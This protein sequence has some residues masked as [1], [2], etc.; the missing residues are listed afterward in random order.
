[1]FNSD[2]K[3]KNRNNILDE[4]YKI[5]IKN[6]IRFVCIGNP[7]Y[8]NNE[9]GDIDILIKQNDIQKGI[10]LIRNLFENFQ[11]IFFLERVTMST[12]YSNNI[13]FLIEINDDNSP[14]LQIDL[15]DSLHWK[16]F[17]Y[18]HYDELTN[19]IIK[20]KNIYILKGFTNNYL[21]VLKDILYKN[22]IN[23][24]RNLD[25]LLFSDIENFIYDIGF[26]KNCSKK[27]LKNY[28]KNLISKLIFINMWLKKSSFFYLKG[29]FFFYKNSLIAYINTLFKNKMIVFYGPDGAGKSFLISKIHQKEILFRYFDEIII[30]HSKP[31]II[32]PLSKFKNLFLKSLKNKDIKRDTIPM[33]PITS[34]LHCL[35][36]GFD[37]FLEKISINFS[38]ISPK[39]KL[40]IYDRHVYEMA[41]QQTFKKLPII[42]ISFLKLI[43]I[44]PLIAFFITGNPKNIFK[45]KQELSED[46]IKYQINK[47]KHLDKNYSLGTIYIDNSSEDFNTTVEKIMEIIKNKI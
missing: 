7:Y 28:Q 11:N 34:I 23:S 45:R 31:K 20:N 43:S 40:F 16:G 30:N 1:M 17:I 41:Y 5:L 10:K 46:E 35:Y 26:S 2:L 6:E 39:R 38:I 15:F 12:N 44:K 3:T 36:Y 25:R 19:F 24:K 37:Y 27:F 14:I 47:F 9:E 22:K 21:G 42:F 8:I 13:K 4:F 18:T 32:P 29:L 33:N